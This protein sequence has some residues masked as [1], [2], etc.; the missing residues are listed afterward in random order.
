[1]EYLVILVS[2]KGYHTFLNSIELIFAFLVFPLL[3]LSQTHLS[4][5]DGADGTPGPIP[6]SFVISWEDVPDAVLYEYV[7]TDN[8]NCFEGCAGDTRQRMVQGTVALEYD[9]R[10]QRFYYWITRIYFANGDTSAWTKVSSFLAITPP[11]NHAITIFPNPATNG[12]AFFRVDWGKDAR[13]S[14]VL[15]DRISLEGRVGES[16]LL[17]RKPNPFDR[18]TDFP[19]EMNA[20]TGAYLLRF[21]LRNNQNELLETQIRKW[22]VR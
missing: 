6:K 1:M 4:P 16:P 11:V 5:A 20:G 18:F 9:L 3:S 10:D 12:K 7:L 2:M 8:Q 21:S 13:I 15:V 17:F 22:I 14:E 19:F